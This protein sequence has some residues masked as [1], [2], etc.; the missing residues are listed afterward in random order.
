MEILF[1]GD[2]SLPTP[3]IIQEVET[4]PEQNSGFSFQRLEDFCMFLVMC[5]KPEMLTI[6]IQTRKFER[7]LSQKMPS[8]VLGRNIVKPLAAS[9]FLLKP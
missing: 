7:K 4:G 8:L 2:L 9:W 1:N 6:I 5:L 3:I